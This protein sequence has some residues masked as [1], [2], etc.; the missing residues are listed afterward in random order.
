VG[1]PADAAAEVAVREQSGLP[2]NAAIAAVAR[3]RGLP[4]GEVYDAVV[5][6]RSAERGSQP[7]HPRQRTAR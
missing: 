6:T 4:R 7:R 5:Q 1:S 3:E 2:R